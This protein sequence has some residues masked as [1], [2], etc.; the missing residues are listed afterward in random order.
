V[1]SEFS[2]IDV[3]DQLGLRRGVQAQIRGH[4]GQADELKDDSP[5]QPRKD[6]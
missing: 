6:L 1:F 2:V 4:A 3:R 5:D